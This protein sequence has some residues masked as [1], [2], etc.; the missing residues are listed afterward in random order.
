MGYIGVFLRPG[1]SRQ[2][3]VEAPSVESDVAVALKNEEG[4]TTIYILEPD[5][6]LRPSAHYLP[7]D[8]AIAKLLFGKKIGDSVEMPD[9]SAATISW[10]KPKFL[11]ALHDV[12]DDFPN[13]FPEAEGF[14]RVKIDSDRE[15]GLEPILER[16]RDRHEAA[17]QVGKLYKSGAMTLSII[18]KSLGCDPV[19]AMVGLASFGSPIRVCAGTHPE[20]DKALAAIDANGAKGCVVDAVTLH[21]VRRLKIEHAVNGVCGPIHIV[22]ETSLHLQRKIHEL[23]ERIDEPECR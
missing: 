17:Q 22:D 6:A 4:A 21:V 2:L 19:E 7:P 18:G 14:E 1:H 10:I 23:N 11:Q 3:S 12:M 13:R 8:H 9:K 20:R 16:L 15:G 5:A